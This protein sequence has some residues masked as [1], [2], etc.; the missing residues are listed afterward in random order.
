M[1]MKIMEVYELEG[2]AKNFGFYVHG[3]GHSVATSPV[4]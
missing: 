1:L 4:N 3:R 2:A